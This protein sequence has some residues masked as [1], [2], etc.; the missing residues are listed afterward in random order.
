MV[1]TENQYF[2]RLVPLFIFS[3]LL[4]GEKQLVF[5]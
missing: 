3:S 2:F 4:F 5:I 1:D